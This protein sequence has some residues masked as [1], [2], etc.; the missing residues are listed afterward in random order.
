[1][2]C[3]PAASGLTASGQ[4]SSISGQIV[5]DTLSLLR[6]G[7]TL[8]ETESKFWLEFISDNLF[9]SVKYPLTISAKTNFDQEQ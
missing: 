4:Q 8:V 9:M 7:P 1:M 6:Y 3:N 2:T 5:L